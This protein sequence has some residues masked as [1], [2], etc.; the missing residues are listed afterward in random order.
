MKI[1]IRDLEFAACRRFQPFGNGDHVVVVEIHAR[2]CERR[3][4]LLR[5]LD[6]ISGAPLRVEF[7]D[8]ISLGVADTIG[9]HGRPVAILLGGT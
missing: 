6:D 5:L 7:D 9:E 8:T 3:L 4:R 1:H 2:N